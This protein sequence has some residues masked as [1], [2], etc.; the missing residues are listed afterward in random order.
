MAQITAQTVASNL[1]SGA[2]LAGVGILINAVL[3]VVKITAGLVGHSYALIA[4]GFESTLDIVSSLIM[5]GALKVAAKPPDETHPYGHGKAE[6]IAAVLG[7]LT[8]IVAALGLAVESVREIFTPH[9]A[10]AP[11]TLAVLIGVLVIKEVLFRKVSRL[12]DAAQ[13]TAI[14]TDAMHHRSDAFTSGAAFIGISIALIGGPGY[15]SADDWAALCACGLIAFNSLRLL[16]PAIYEVMDTA[17]AP[18]IEQR[19]RSVAGEV[20]GVVEVER[21]RIRKMGLEFYV[22]LHIGVAA[23]ITVREGHAIA[24]LVKNAVRAAEPAIADVLVHVE[25][26]DA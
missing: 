22:D 12:A 3:A 14:K 2:R 7:S 4:D 20:P 17:P 25:P 26:A 21:C 23:E 9:H 5:W 19:V 10:P 1:E 16:K 18:E 6:P 11:F 15:E 8:V 24:H 13:S